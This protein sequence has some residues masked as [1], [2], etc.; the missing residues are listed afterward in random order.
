MT[1]RKSLIAGLVGSAFLAGSASAATLNEN[2]ENFS[3]NW[4]M[5]TVVAKGNTDVSGTGA[6]EWQGGDRYDVFHFSGLSGAT[7]LVLDF[8]LLGNYRDGN[9]QNA[10][11]SI[12]YSYVPFTGGYYAHKSDGTQLSGQDLLAGTFDATYDP[13]DRTNPTKQGTSRFELALGGDFAG[14]LFLA[15]DFTYGKI[16]YTVSSP[17]WDN[18]QIDTLPPSAVPLPAAGLLLFAGFSG[19]ALVAARRRRA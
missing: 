2:D 3:G 14:D 13:W 6:P 11:G 4:A 1:I 16:G 17:G 7:S 5:P 12:Y 9:Y 8:T 19:L 10:G 18:A 15:L